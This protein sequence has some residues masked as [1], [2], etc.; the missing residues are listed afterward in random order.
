MA[1]DEWDDYPGDLPK[2]GDHDRPA[3]GEAAPWLNDFH[4]TRVDATNVEGIDEQKHTLGCV[5]G[6]EGDVTI[7]KEKGVDGAYI[8]STVDAITYL[9]E[10]GSR[11]DGAA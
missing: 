11:G 10:R 3:D 5:C 8:A 4:G 7:V 2:D 9:Q 1:L 6:C